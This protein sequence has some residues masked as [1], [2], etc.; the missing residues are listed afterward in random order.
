MSFT[1]NDVSRTS[2]LNHRLIFMTRVCAAIRIEPWW[3]IYRFR[4][5]WVSTLVHDDE[6]VRHAEESPRSLALAFMICWVGFRRI[7]A[8]IGSR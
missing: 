6:T 2:G 7:F 8:S 1:F 4:R 5:T 3:T